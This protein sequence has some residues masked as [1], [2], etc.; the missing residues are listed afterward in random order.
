MP[1]PR[2]SGARR[3]LRRCDVSAWSRGSTWSVRLWL[4]SPRFGRFDSTPVSSPSGTGLGAPERSGDD[5]EPLLPSCP[6]DGA[7]VPGAGAGVPGSTVGVGSVGGVGSGGGGVGVPLSTGPIEIG[8]PMMSVRPARSAMVVPG[9]RSRITESSV[10]SA[11]C[12]VTRWSSADAGTVRTVASRATTRRASA[13]PPRSLR[14]T[15][16]SRA[17]ASSHNYCRVFR[18]MPY[19]KV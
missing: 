2:R 4:G 16:R 10:P 14:I 5:P 18:E 11:S 3:P 15:L 1:F 12:T 6:G 9:G 17:R 8:V 7:G 13:R 19:R